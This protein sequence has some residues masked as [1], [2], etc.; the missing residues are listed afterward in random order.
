MLHAPFPQ[1]TVTASIQEK[2]KIACNI[3]HTK[4]QGAMRRRNGGIP[5]ETLQYMFT[6]FSGQNPFNVFS[7]IIV[8]FLIHKIPI[9]K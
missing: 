1:V 3:S 9:I 6:S 4:M 2:L 8:V 5:W 7:V